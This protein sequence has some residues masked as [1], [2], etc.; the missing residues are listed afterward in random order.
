MESKRQDGEKETERAVSSVA[1]GL[2]GLQ[3]GNVRAEERDGEH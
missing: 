1:E 3:L 2:C